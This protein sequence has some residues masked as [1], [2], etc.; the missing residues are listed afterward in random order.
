[1]F[2]AIKIL[3]SRIQHNIASGKIR[4]GFSEYA[5]KVIDIQNSTAYF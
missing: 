4:A 3:F 2:P 1:M 5:L